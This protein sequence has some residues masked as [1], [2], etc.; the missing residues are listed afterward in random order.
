MARNPSAAPNAATI[1][2]Q[3]ARC[4]DLRRQGKSIRKIA[5][6]TGIARS[7]VQDRIDAAIA[8]IV[9]PAADGVRTL[10]LERLDAWLLR[11]EESMES[12]EDPARIV[13][14]AIRVSER[15]ARLLGLDEPVKAEVTTLQLDADPDVAAALDRARQAKERE[16][17]ALR[18][19][20]GA[21]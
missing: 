4:L 3:Q 7:T 10:E 19:S 15:R 5:E 2:D 1:A 14:V 16:I 20:E 18:G 6:E 12:G 9:H 11:L 21:A 8:E 17:D 13:P